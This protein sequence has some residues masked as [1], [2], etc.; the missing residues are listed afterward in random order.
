MNEKASDISARK[1]VLNRI[2][3]EESI[4]ARMEIR[5]LIKRL[6]VG[7]LEMESRYQRLDESYRKSIGTIKKG[8]HS[9]R[10]VYKSRNMMG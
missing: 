5:K 6:R 9:S 1:K 8:N 3:Q 10:R 7:Y 4:T 2:D